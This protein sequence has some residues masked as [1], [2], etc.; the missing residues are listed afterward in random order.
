MPISVRGPKIAIAGKLVDLN[1]FGLIRGRADFALQTS[2]VDV[3]FD[4]NAATTTDRLNDAALLTFALTNL[5]LTIGFGAATLRITGG[6]LGIASIKPP[7]ATAPT[8][9]TRSSTAVTGKEL[10][11]TLTIP[12][13]QGSVT[14]ASIRVNRA[15]GQLDPTPANATSG[16]EVKA[17]ALNWAT[18]ATTPAALTVDLDGSGGWTV[19][20]AL[21]D[22]G[23]GLPDPT[24]MPITLRGSQLAVAGSIT[25]LNLFGILRGGADFAVS[26]Q[27]VDI[28]FDGSAS[29]TNDRLTDASLVTFALSNLNLRLGTDE[30]GLQIGPGGTIGI[31]SI[32][33]P[34]PATGTGTDD[35]TWTAV[36]GKDLAVSLDLPG[37]TASVSA[38]ALK[39]NRASGQFTPTTGSPCSHR[40]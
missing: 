3:D 18:A 5:D 27:M 1:V 40:R 10:S 29:T 16:D 39:I 38:G 24:A 12:G 33:A 8:T 37:I 14:A 6:S 31:A 19:P 17:V 23:S 7:A 35:R 22:P 25:G 36:V 11:V 9:D 32:S 21:V 4:G 26:S 34:T 2:V 15:S 20:T 30:V 13:I 28:D